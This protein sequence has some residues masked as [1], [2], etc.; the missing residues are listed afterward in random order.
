MFQLHHLTER[1]ENGVALATILDRY[2]TV[3]KFPPW[4]TLPLSRYWSSCRSKKGEKEP[5]K[6]SG[7]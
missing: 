4:T 3:G 6:K 2:A 1:L 7:K 5:G